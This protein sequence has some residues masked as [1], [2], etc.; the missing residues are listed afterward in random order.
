MNIQETAVQL[1]D[2][3]ERIYASGS[4]SVGTDQINTIYIYELKRGFV[5]HRQN[6][7]KQANV[8]GIEQ[9]QIV[10]RYMGKILP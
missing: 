1:Q 10:H 7:I 6:M 2:A 5:K 8:A 9:F 3:L 4:L